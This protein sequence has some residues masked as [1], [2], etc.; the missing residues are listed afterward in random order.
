MPRILF[1][2]FF[3]LGYERRHHVAGQEAIPMR[4]LVV[5]VAL[6]IF[7]LSAIA[8]LT[9]DTQATINPA[10]TLKPSGC[11]SCAGTGAVAQ[12]ERVGSKPIPGTNETMLVGSIENLIPI[13]VLTVLG[14]ETCSAEAVNWA[15]QQGSSFEDVERTLRTVEAMQKLDCF[16]TQFGPDVN[17]RMSKP[18]A[19]AY[20]ALT[21]AKMRAAK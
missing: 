5:V 15:L 10:S 17:L 3:R 7:S 1:N 20:E 14:C 6:S 12:T 18:L 16:K 4:I 8:Q 13:G 21:Q 9:T 19:T 11:A 2:P